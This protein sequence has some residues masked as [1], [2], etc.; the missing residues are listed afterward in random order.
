MDAWIHET[1]IAMVVPEGSGRKIFPEHF[2]TLASY[3]NKSLPIGIMRWLQLLT[4]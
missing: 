2:R 3:R 4:T 1:A